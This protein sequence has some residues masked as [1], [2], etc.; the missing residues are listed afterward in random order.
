MNVFLSWSGDRSRAVALALRD[1]LPDVLQ[2]IQPFMSEHDI[3]A[4]A[5]WAT[6]LG[7]SLE[8][9][10]TGIVCLTPENIG[11]PWVLFEAGSLAKKLEAACVIPFRL[12]LKAA[13]IPYP[14]AQFQGLDVNRDGTLTL[15]ETLNN[16]RPQPMETERLERLFVKLW[17]D[18]EGDLMKAA[19]IPTTKRQQRTEREILEEMLQ[20]TR[21]NLSVFTTTVQYQNIGF[22]HTG[23]VD[24]AASHATTA[25]VYWHAKGFTRDQAL[26]FCG[27]MKNKGIPCRFAEHRDKRPPDAVFIGAL[28]PA[29]F[30]R[31]ALRAIPYKVSYIF[32]PDYPEEQGGSSDGMKIGIGYRSTHFDTRRE[33]HANPLPL[34]ED[35]FADLVESG[36]TSVE[37]HA[38]LRRITNM[39]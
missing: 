31:L 29:E 24:A 6:S 37:F 13:E 10:D 38:R 7:K 1:W 11:A 26:E 28:V 27:V 30:A 4:G 2:N 14:L 20:L 33:P 16:I 32:R 5:R 22:E 25:D 35:G 17:G 19:T 21:N 18:I 15:L 8:T 9:T 3:G 36:I 39:T 34:S 12:N 23:D